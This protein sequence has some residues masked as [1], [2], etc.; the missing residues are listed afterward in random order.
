MLRFD[1]LKFRLQYNI[2]QSVIARRRNI[3]DNTFAFRMHHNVMRDQR[4]FFDAA[5]N[6]SSRNTITNL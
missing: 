6:I 3:R 1:I 2:F 5:E 4:V